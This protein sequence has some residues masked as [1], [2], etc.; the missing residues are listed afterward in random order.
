MKPFYC[1]DFN[2]PKVYEMNFSNFNLKKSDSL[3]VVGA[4]INKSS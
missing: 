4:K 3:S 2:F 1:H